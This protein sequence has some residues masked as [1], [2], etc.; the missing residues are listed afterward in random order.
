MEDI[1]ER[2]NKELRYK[3]CCHVSERKLSQKVHKK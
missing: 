3:Q 2:L 1:S